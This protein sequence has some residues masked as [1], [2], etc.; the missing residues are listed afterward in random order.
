MAFRSSPS[1][2]TSKRSGL[3]SCFG[4]FVVVGVGIGVAV[5]LAKYMGHAPSTPPT[6]RFAV[7]PAKS[8]RST[9]SAK[10]PP[11]QSLPNVDPSTTLTLL[12][13]EGAMV[14]EPWK[15]TRGTTDWWAGTARRD[16]PNDAGL[17]SELSLFVESTNKTTTEQITFE[18]EVYDPSRFG[19]TV[20]SE[21]SRLV[22]LLFLRLGLTMPAELPRSIDK[23]ESFEQT[24]AFGRVTFKRRTHNAGYDYVLEIAAIESP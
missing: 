2:P 5:P 24:T 23:E 19:A 3:N 17:Q 16:W 8:E 6:Q 13:D 20:K 21:F 4:C 11:K 12:V 7:P 18:G 15:L 22:P 10:L 1:Q 9:S 14:V